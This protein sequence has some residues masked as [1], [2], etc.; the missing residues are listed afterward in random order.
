MQV[1][2]LKKLVEKDKIMKENGIVPIRK[3]RA[4]RISKNAIEVKI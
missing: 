3:G 4:T 1:E 2:G